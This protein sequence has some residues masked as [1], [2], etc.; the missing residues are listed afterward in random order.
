MELGNIFLNDKEEDKFYRELRG[1]LFQKVYF[2]TDDLLAE[3]IWIHI[4]TRP[5]RRIGNNRAIIQ[6][7]CKWN[8]FI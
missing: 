2:K 8:H 1:L 7:D 4:K 5:L 6:D 3:E